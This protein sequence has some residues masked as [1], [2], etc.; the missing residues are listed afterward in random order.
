MKSCCCHPRIGER[1]YEKAQEGIADAND[2][3]DAADDNEV[4]D[5]VCEY[6]CV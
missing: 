4:P 1:G 6:V 3:D 5:N 2:Y